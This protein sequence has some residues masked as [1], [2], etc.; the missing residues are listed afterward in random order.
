M[1]YAL[2]IREDSENEKR[3]EVLLLPGLLIAEWYLQ[4]DL[5]AAKFN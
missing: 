1:K 3:K 2:D 5:K 4:S